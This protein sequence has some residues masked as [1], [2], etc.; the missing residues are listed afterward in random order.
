[1]KHTAPVGKLS[2][3]WAMSVLRRMGYTKRKV[4]SKM[5]VRFY[6]INLMR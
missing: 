1:M 3:E 4:S 6:Q 2:K 5:Y